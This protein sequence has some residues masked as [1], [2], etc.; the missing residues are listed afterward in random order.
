MTE[1]GDKSKLDRA[2]VHYE[3]AKP[4]GG[5]ILGVVTIVVSVIF[6]IQSVGDNKYYPKISGEMLERRL[7]EQKVE[8]DQ[9][10]MNLNTI[11]QQNDK[12]ITI[13]EKIEAAR[14]KR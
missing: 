10:E 6:W 5:L 8:V 14:S 3:R 11:E 12:I 2:M 7:T 4:L 13:L 1:S 9:L